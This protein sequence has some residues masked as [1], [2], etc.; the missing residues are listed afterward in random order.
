MKKLI[1][2]VFI[3]FE[4]GEGCGKSTHVDL[5][6]KYLRG[7]GYD[8]V[9]TCE[10]GA[11]RIGKVFR[12]ML[13]K[14][15]EKLHPFSE[16]LLF[17]ADRVEHVNKLIRPALAKGKIVIS[18]RYIDSTTAYQCGGR[19]LSVKLVNTLN[20]VSSS[21]L[22]P[23]MTVL[24]DISP[25]DGFARIKGRAKWDKFENEGRSFHERVR[26]AY[27]EIAKK[28]PSRIKMI[29]SAGSIKDVQNSI[30]DLVE[31]LIR[32]YEKL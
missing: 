19:G 11:T 4:G 18:D 14:G 28:N 27:L 13:L 20:L 2:G 32:R 24:L 22:I 29:P 10:P 6:A 12:G 8:V 3:T 15:D 7:K 16:I 26:K 5:L 23:N 30:K 17:A 31:A 9:T 1:K 21:G 25:K